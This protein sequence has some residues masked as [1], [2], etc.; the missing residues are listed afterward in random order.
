[1]CKLF[2]KE[3]SRRF[4]LWVFLHYNSTIK[5]TQMK[6][7]KYQNIV[8]LHTNINEVR[9]VQVKTVFATHAH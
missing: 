1:M 9:K 7:T 8:S 6:Y 2:N 4:K 5:V 3:Q